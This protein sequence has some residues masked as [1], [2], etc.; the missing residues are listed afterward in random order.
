MACMSV[1]MDEMAWP[2]ASLHENFGPFSVIVTT[3]LGDYY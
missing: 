1:D 3:I 2:N